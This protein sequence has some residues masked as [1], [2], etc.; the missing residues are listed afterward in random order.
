MRH[1]I[2]EGHEV[3]LISS[4]PCDCSELPVASLHVVPLDFSARLRAGIGGRDARTMH[5][6][7]Q[8]ARLRGNPI[9]KALVRLRYLSVPWAVRLQR[10]RLRRIVE[11]IGPDIVHVMR[12]PFEGI[13]AAEA[14][15][16]VPVPL[17]LSVWGIDFTLLAWE[18]PSIA[19]LTR[20]ALVRADGLHPD[21]RRDLRLAHDLGFAANKPAAVL[22]GYGGVKREIFQPGPRDSALAAR[23][24]LP[25][26]VRSS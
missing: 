16:D 13:L 24:G 25:E 15:W 1:L 3:H 18:T 11:Q 8:I 22:P 12:I 6:S 17:I 21:C 23:L 19:R 9:W 10:S 26:G 4:Y 20:L 5:G 7:P 14:F 2:R